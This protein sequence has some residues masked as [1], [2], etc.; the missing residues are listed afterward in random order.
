MRRKTARRW[1]R[2]FDRVGCPA[3]VDGVAGSYHHDGGS[4]TLSSHRIF[5]CL[6]MSLPRCA[7]LPGDLCPSGGQAPPVRR[8]GGVHREPRKGLR[9][10]TPRLRSAGALAIQAA[11]KLGRRQVVR[12]RLLVPP[13]AGSNPAAPASPPDRAGSACRPLAYGRLIS[14]CQKASRFVAGRSCTNG[15]CGPGFQKIAAATASVSLSLCVTRKN[16]WHR[17]GIR[18]E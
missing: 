15:G 11:S 3:L 9:R 16:T 1:R 13:F 17:T 12:Q 7:D 18:W 8:N 14:P 5:T 4:A 2:A 6:W 10:T